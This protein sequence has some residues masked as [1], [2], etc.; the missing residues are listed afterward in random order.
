M[1]PLEM[2]VAPTYVVGF[3]MPVAIVVRS[4]RAGE[5]A[6]PYVDAFTGARALGVV[7][8]DEGGAVVVDVSAPRFVD[9][10]LYTIVPL[11]SG[12]SRRAL[13]DVSSV[14]GA[15]APGKYRLTVRYA[16]F[17]GI[18]SSAP[19]TIE[20]RA[21]TPDE[22]R[23]LDELSPKK[24]PEQSWSDWSLEPPDRDVPWR[25]PIALF[26][27]AGPLRLHVALRS[28]IF[29][30]DPVLWERETLEHIGAPTAPEQEAIWAEILGMRYES[31]ML[32]TQL[33]RVRATHPSL[34]WWADAIE[35][36]QG[37]IAELRASFSPLA[38]ADEG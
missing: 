9:P 8:H 25:S 27:D 12:E 5:T 29:G 16:T 18:T 20:L 19:A 23:L 30:D 2:D 10:E 1:A 24:R 37:P 15:P 32:A 36:G 3:P 33:T 7:L 28:L 35:S 21:P 11:R 38:R 6:V 22:Q 31:V 4:E 17:L 14:I 26:H 13:V 34:A